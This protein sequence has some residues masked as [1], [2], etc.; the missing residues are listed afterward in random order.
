MPRVNYIHFPGGDEF[1]ACNPLWVPSGFNSDTLR[2]YF[3]SMKAAGLEWVRHDFCWSYIQHLDKDHWR[4]DNYDQFV[5]IANEC[6]IKILAI[7][8]HAPRWAWV[9]PDNGSTTNMPRDRDQFVA[10]VTAT[11]Q[12]YT[13][14]G[15][16]HWEIWNE[17]N[18]GTRWV[19]DQYAYYVI[20]SYNAIKEIN[21]NATVLAGPSAGNN[22]VQFLSDM[23]SQTHVEGYFDALTAHPYNILWR[24]LPALHRVMSENGDGAKKIWLTEYGAPT[25]GA[26]GQNMVTEAQQAID[27]AAAVHNARHTSFLGPLFFYNWKDSQPYSYEG[28]KDRE[29]YFGMVHSDLT[30]KPSYHA[31]R[32][33]IKRAAYLP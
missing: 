25:N 20:V 26:S 12:R 9:D 10:F 4:W 3:A 31:I 7:F 1:G 16:D 21:P 22:Q 33:A 30:P 15:V 24:N 2:S 27:L 8:N 23:Y 5:S 29:M 11:V 6:G 13:P 32:R 19:A 14:L 18:L 28:T 17:P